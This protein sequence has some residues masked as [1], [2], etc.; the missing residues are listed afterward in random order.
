MPFADVHPS[1]ARALEERGYTDPTPVQAAVMGASRDKD[2]LVSARTGSGKTVGFGLALQELLLTEQ[3]AG[4]AGLPKALVVAPTRELAVQVQ[5]ELQWLYG[6][7]GARV[8]AAVGGTDIVRQIRALKDGVHV[9]VGTPGRLCDLLDRGVLHLE[10]VRAVVLDEADEMLDMGFREE[11]ETL[12]DATPPERRTLLF[13]ATLPP[14]ILEM[15]KKYQKEAERIAVA[16]EEAHADIVYRAVVVAPEEREHALVNVLRHVDQP[17]LVFVATREGVTR[18]HSRLVE[19]GFA[20]AALSGEFS[21]QERS[22]SLQALRDGRARVLVATDVAAR[23]LDVPDLG[24]VIHA[25]LPMDPAVLLHRSGRTGRAGK[26]GMA[27]LIVPYPRRRNAQR[28]LRDAKVQ[29][30]WMPP[31]SAADVIAKDQER[32]AQELA[33][34]AEPT[35]EDRAVAKLLL[36]THDPEALVAAL[37]RQRRDELPAPEDL[38]ST[39]R[40]G[41]AAPEDAPVVRPVRDPVW[42]RVNVGRSD[43]A[44]PHWLVPLICR[45]GGVGKQAIGAIRIFDRE[46]RFEIAGDVADDFEFQSRKPDRREPQIRFQRWRD[47]R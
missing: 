6:P 16:T 30:Q 42:F 32:L 19:R 14:P 45:R 31:P 17:A 13:S 37:V 22:R 18:L 23:G 47:R 10:Q 9:V 36:A 41:E 21:Q 3:G 1:L 26:K 33:P 11:L 7:S 25:D 5:R 39:L 24:L 43:N 8:A 4:P 34:D 2:L 46:T 44:H 35:D 12:L 40:L 38:P 29:A 15:A 27:V 28:L 20:A